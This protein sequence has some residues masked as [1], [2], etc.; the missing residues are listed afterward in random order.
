MATKSTS[1]HRTEGA[2]W[3]VPSN[4]RTFDAEAA[5][6]DAD[7]VHWSETLQSKAMAVGDIVYLYST[8]PIKAITHKCQILETGLS[9]PLATDSRHWTDPQAAE[10][11]RTR[12][13]MRLKLLLTLDEETRRALSLESLR[14]HGLR[15]NIAGRF[16]PSGQLFDYIAD[17]QPAR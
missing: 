1:D 9:Q 15:G 12:T 13:W 17:N 2:T 3:V 8:T 5:F 10:D 11:R 7:T 4:P 14:D 6:S 16:R